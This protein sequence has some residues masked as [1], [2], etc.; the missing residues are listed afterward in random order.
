MWRSM[1]LMAAVG[2]AFVALATSTAPAHAD[3]AL[4]QKTVAKQ[5]YKFKRTYLKQNEKCLGKENKLDIPG[6]CP[7]TAAQ[8]KIADTNSKVTATISDPAKCTMADLSTIG[9]RSD[10]A[11][12]AASGGVEANCAALPVTT[13]AEFAE[14]MKCWKAAEMGEFIALLFASHATEICGTLDENSTTCSDLDCTTPL[15]EQRNLGDTGENDCQ[16]GISRA[17]IKY[18][19]KRAKILEKCLLDGGTQSSCLADLDVQLKLQKAEESKQTG[20]KRK[21][22]NRTPSSSTGFCCQC[23]TGNACMVIADRPTCEATSGCV[24]QEGKTCDGGTLK[25]MPSHEITWWSN[26][27]ESDTC[28]GATLTTIDDLISCVDSSADQ[29]ADEVLCLQF[30]GYPCPAAEPN[31]TPTP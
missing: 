9:Y 24:V 17:G 4:C 25:C 13:T 21:C 11:Y 29:I 10:C 5:L 31:P 16:R 1:Q 15:P 19:L 8:L 20:I 3:P 23:G 30:P 12:E 27:P 14:C 2:T 22:G 7:D 18:L 26:C 28:P 6:P